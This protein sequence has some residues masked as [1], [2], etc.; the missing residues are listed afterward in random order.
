MRHTVETMVDIIEMQSPAPGAHN[1][2]LSIIGLLT[3]Y[4]ASDIHY[5]ISTKH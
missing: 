3:E 1:G 2:Y 5:Y 4:Q